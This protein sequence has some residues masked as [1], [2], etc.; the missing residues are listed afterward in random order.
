MFI[1]IDP[2]ETR[3]NSLF[4]PSLS[5]IECPGLEADTGADFVIARLPIPPTETLQLHIDHKSLFCQRKS[6]YD[7]IGDFNQ[8]WL[9][10][11]RF[12]ALKIPMG[13]CFII[14]IGIFYPDSSGYLKIENKRQPANLEKISY[15]TYLKNEAGWGYSG[16]Q[17][18]RLNNENELEFFIQAQ[19]EEFQ[20][21]EDRGNLKEVYSRGTA[22]VTNDPF[23]E[24]KEIDDWRNL[25]LS[26]LKGFGLKT[27]QS[28]GDYIDQN[29]DHI[30]HSGYWA[31][32]ILTDQNEKGKAIHDIPGWGEVSRK[33]LRDILGLPP[34]V[35]LSVTHLEDRYDYEAGWNA[36][37]DLFRELVEKGKSPVEAYNQVKKIEIPF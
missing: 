2:S 21:I 24:V 31:L 33:R 20:R 22:F 10:I 19:V 5:T 26:G 8:I 36:S 4:P 11:A 30:W 9:E 25:L 37:I 35:N 6:G 29:L 1:F 16:A 3:S 12:Q 7:A 15:L 23:Q 28:L 13:Q 34:T 18:R 17:V 32:K 14:P 27:A